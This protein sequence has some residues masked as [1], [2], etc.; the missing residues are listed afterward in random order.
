MRSPDFWTELRICLF[1]IVIHGLVCRV[2]SGVIWSYPTCG[3]FSWSRT[4]LEVPANVFKGWDT[5]CLDLGSHS[6]GLTCRIQ[7]K[8]IPGFPKI[9]DFG[10][11]WGQPPW[12]TPLVCLPTHQFGYIWSVH[13]DQFTSKCSFAQNHVLKCQETFF[14]N[15]PPPHTKWFLKLGIE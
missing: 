10:F 2:L 6:F 1:L 4:M 14:S 7:H 12:Y 5:H 13:G 3:F 9:N 15:S 8:R 11:Y